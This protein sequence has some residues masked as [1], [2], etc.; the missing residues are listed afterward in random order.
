MK[1]LSTVLV[2]EKADWIFTPSFLSLVELI[3]SLYLWFQV[4]F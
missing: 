2:V 4:H 3:M 1:E